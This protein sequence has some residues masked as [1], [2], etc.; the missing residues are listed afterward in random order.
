M[1]NRERSDPAQQGDRDRNN[2]IDDESTVG[3]TEDLRG[4]G[5]DDE[6]EDFDEE[7]T[8]DLEEDEEEGI[9]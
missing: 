8:E 5:D 9:R 7:E 2:E 3:G 4:V 6:E 1:A